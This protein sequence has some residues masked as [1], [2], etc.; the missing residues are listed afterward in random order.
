MTEVKTPARSTAPEFTV[1]QRSQA[2]IVLRRFLRHKLAVWSLIAFI[3]IVLFAYVGASIWKYQ[4]TDI[5]PDNSQPPSLL[6]PFGTDSLGHDGLAQVLRGMQQ[7]IK[8][9]LAVALI[10]TIL[11]VA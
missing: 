5:T 10:G 8:I 11:G 9:A 4:Y 3:L 6:H 2:E 7:S 1:R